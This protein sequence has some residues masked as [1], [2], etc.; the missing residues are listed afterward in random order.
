MCGGFMRQIKRMITGLLVFCLWGC[1]TSVK[2]IPKSAYAQS[3]TDYY[4]VTGLQTLDQ[5]YFSVKVLSYVK[6]TDV[7]LSYYAYDVL[8]APKT[9]LAITKLSVLV[10]PDY[11]VH[12]LLEPY[13][14]DTSGLLWKIYPVRPND[15][16]ASFQNLRL[17]ELIEVP[18]GA[19]RLRG[20]LVDGGKANYEALGV[21]ERDMTLAMS[22]LTITIKTA[23][24]NETFTFRLGT[25]LSSYTK[26]TVPESLMKENTIVSGIVHGGLVVR[27]GEYLGD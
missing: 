27:W 15:I 10:T 3:L 25:R 19:M 24:V 2:P 14:N 22:R 21:S 7:N 4:A 8:I 23:T 9:T 16:T 17:S 26:D 20:Y 13:F 12:Q 5:T 18:Y 1:S 11:E 6:I